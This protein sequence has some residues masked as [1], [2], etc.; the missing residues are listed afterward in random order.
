MKLEDA[1]AKLEDVAAQARVF[2][3]SESDRAVTTETLGLFAEMIREATEAT[4]VVGQA[5]VE[6]RDGRS[7]AI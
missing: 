4:A 2:E 3:G 5:L 7:I 6:I 1:I